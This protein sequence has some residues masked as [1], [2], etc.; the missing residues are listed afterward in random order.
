MPRSRSLLACLGRPA[1]ALVA[2]P[3]YK[4]FLLG[5]LFLVAAINYADRNAVTALLP[6]LRSD[7]G[8]S[9]S[10]LA[11]VGSFFQWSYALAV[12]VVGYLG[13]CLSRR[14]IVIWSLTAW[15]MVTALTG[16]AATG[17][18]LLSMRVALGMTQAF[19]VPTALALL[20]EHHS[21]KTRAR[22]MSVHFAGLNMGTVAGGTFAGY[23]G[24]LQNWRASFFILGATG[25]LLALFCSFTVY[26]NVATGS[27]NHRSDAVRVR[28]S[29]VASLSEI[30]RIPSVL[31]LAVE[32]IL[33]SMSTWIFMNWLP[34]YF[35]ESFNLT[36]TGAGFFGTLTLT[37]GTVIGVILGGY[38]SDRV[39]QRG[40]KYRMVVQAVAH[41]A[42]APLLLAFFWSDSF[43]KVFGCAVLFFIFRGSSQANSNPLV[44]EL[45]DS[46]RRGTAFGFLIMMAALSGGLGVQV[47]GY[48]KQDFGLGAIFAAIS[49]MVILTVLLLTV[50]YLVFLDRDLKRAA[51]A[52][53]VGK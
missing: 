27:P 16:L 37:A 7:L 15:S 5:V 38:V 29:F 39:A 6:L 26:Q 49:G 24:D 47:T 32:A 53:G 48:F 13:D 40:A 50:G 2:V 23:L 35:R 51:I 22:A 8:M 20:A 14:S 9:D 31:I 12:P 43:S 4:W 30:L 3:T 10:E 46:Q 19:Y 17:S 18:Q 33:T 36:L 41:M 45:V 42:G 25:L 34:L 28:S 44:C 1:S 21:P 11:A 52:Y